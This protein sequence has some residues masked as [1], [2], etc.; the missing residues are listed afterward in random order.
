M[1]SFF[2]FLQSLNNGGRFALGFRYLSTQRK[3][4]IILSWAIRWR[5]ATRLLADNGMHFNQQC[6]RRG[7]D[8]FVSVVIAAFVFGLL[9]R[10][11]P[12]IRIGFFE[13]HV[14]EFIAQRS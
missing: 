4:F 8:L 9:P 10:P 14:S 2:P 11:R 1:K 5:T 3:G 6:Q 12:V 7:G 13:H